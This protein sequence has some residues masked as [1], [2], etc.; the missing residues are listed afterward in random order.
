MPTDIIE[1]SDFIVLIETSNA[2]E[3]EVAQCKLDDD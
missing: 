2:Q 1:I 3:M